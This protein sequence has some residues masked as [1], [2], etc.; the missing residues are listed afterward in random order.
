MS[1]ASL[2]TRLTQAT[3]TLPQTAMQGVIASPSM[4]SAAVNAAN[5]ATARKAISGKSSPSVANAKPKKK[6]QSPRTATKARKPTPPKPTPASNTAVPPALPHSLS[7]SDAAVAAAPSLPR[8]DSIS[9]EAATKIVADTINA[10]DAEA[11]KRRPRLQLSEPDK[12]AVR[13]HLPMLER[14]LMAHSRLLPVVYMRTR[15]QDPIRKICTIDVLVKEQRR[16]FDEDQYI[17]SPADTVSYFEMLCHFMTMAKEWGNMQQNA[18][19][20]AAAVAAAAPTGQTQLA[21]PAGTESAGSQHGS[22]APLT[23]MH[24]GALT[25]APEYASFEKAVKHPLDANNLRLPP[26]KKRALDKG[27][28]GDVT[29]GALSAP[30]AISGQ[31]HPM[32]Q[33]L[34]Q[35]MQQ[36]KLQSQ[37]GAPFAPAPLVLPANMNKEQFD[38]L[39]LETRS[40]ILQSQQTALIRQN[41]MGLSPTGRF[42]TAISTISSPQHQQHQPHG[43]QASTNPLLLAAV[44]GMSAHGAQSVEEQRLRDLEQ[45]KWNRP[46]EYLMCVLGKFTKGAERAGVEPSPILQ[47]AFWPIA[48]KS[49]SS[50][51]GVV[52]ADAVL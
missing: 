32:Q 42:V 22:T 25:T 36:Q 47:Q 13:D 45:D 5:A 52:A 4:A 28:V 2:A 15:Q 29:A 19:L 38:L 44:Q 17:I 51:W 31:P 33:Q 1:N 14:L 6:S 10:M 8:T 41:A 30:S 24:P 49:M 46:L 18:E 20:T 7:A 26:S 43:D 9:A 35:Q 48:R 16:L 21:A 34:F 39:P 11:I 40:A 27:G 50:G 37:A 12:K 23:N 3:H